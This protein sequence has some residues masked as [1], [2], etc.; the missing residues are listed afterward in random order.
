MFEGPSDLVVL[1][2]SVIPTVARFVE[3][4][5]DRFRMPKPSEPM[6][7]GEVRFLE[8]GPA[9]QVA[10]FAAYAASV[11]AKGG[12]EPSAIERIGATLG[13]YAAQHRR[14]HLVAAPLLGTGAGKLMP[15]I[16]FQALRKGFLAAA[17][18]WATLR[19]HVPDG[20]VLTRIR[21]HDADD[22]G[23][24]FPTPRVF[25]S[26]TKTSDAHAAWVQDLAE[27]LLA[28]GVEARLD[29]WDLSP[30]MDVAQW[31]SNELDLADR[32]L[33]ICN[34]EYA[35]RADRRHGGV[36]WEI[37][38]VQGVLLGSQ[39]DNPDKF[40]PIVRTTDVAQGS[41]GF[42]RSAYALHWPPEMTDAKED[43]ARQSLLKHLFRLRTKPPIG[44]PP[45]Y[46]RPPVTLAGARNQR[47]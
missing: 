17:P 11:E 23:S 43:A 34:D 5:L 31:M 46:V 4:R 45:D 12:T 27:W 25:I 26:Y 13:A 15:E 41:P 2:C 44:Q 32:V 18:E 9:S 3:E 21:E 14:V 38:L 1:P 24:A 47:R 20:P 37:R 35:R 36:G 22:P 29:V 19:V 40:V 8:L 30:G 10:P 39:V 28:H 7:L 42:L 6:Q 16:A 33:L